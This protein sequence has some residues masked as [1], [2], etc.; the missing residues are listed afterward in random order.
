MPL[1]HFRGRFTVYKSNTIYYDNPELFNY[2]KT[3]LNLPYNVTLWAGVSK[4][5]RL[6]NEGKAVVIIQRESPL[7]ERCNNQRLHCSQANAVSR[8]GAR[9]VQVLKH[10]K[11]GPENFSRSGIGAF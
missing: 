11:P 9:R 10:K 3:R 4:S 5:H 8:A 7:R 1:L 6:I 2:D